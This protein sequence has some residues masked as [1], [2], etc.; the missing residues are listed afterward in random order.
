MSM[1]YT[2]P[3]LHSAGSTASCVSQ[4]PPEDIARAITETLQRQKRNA[5]PD[6][7][8]IEALT[9]LTVQPISEAFDDDGTGF[10][11]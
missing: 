11:E 5:D 9:M 10:S 2:P 4:Q 6:Q 8:A 3:D 7:W 1:V